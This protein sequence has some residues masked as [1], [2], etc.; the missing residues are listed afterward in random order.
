V[1]AAASVRFRVRAA[2]ACRLWILSLDSTGEFSRLYPGEGTG[3]AAVSGLVE[4]PGGAVL[5]GRPGPERIY[6][7]CSPG[8]SRWRALAPLLKVQ[9]TSGEAA[10]RAPPS[11]AALPSGT[12]LDSV[13]VEKRT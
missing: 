2:S 9:A 12:Q 13:L 4:I 5:D 3:G 11:A 7:V 10:V 6:A 1:A 8:P